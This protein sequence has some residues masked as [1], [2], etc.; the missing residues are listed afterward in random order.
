[1]PRRTMAS[2]ATMATAEA[3]GRDS[4]KPMQPTPPHKT[5]SAPSHMTCPVMINPPRRRVAIIS[6]MGL[7]SDIDLA[8]RA[9][10]AKIAAAQQALVKARADLSGGEIAAEHLRPARDDVA[11]RRGAAIQH[12]TRKHRDVRQR[13]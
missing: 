8:V 4:R 5:H 1:M 3:A 12:A 2:G 10:M 13:A 6:R 7:P 9:D 11:R